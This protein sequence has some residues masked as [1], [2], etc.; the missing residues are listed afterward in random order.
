MFMYKLFNFP[1]VNV[2]TIP[3][4]SER[5]DYL[6]SQFYN[7]NVKNIKINTFK[8]FEPGDYIFDGE[9]VNLLVDSHRGIVSS[10]LIS[11]KNWY[12][13]TNEQYSIF[14]EDDL[15]L[16]TVNFWPF[17]WSTF[18]CALPENWG[19]IQLVL[20]KENKMTDYDFCFRQRNWDDWSACCYMIKR[21][22]AKKI[23]D[24]YYKKNIFTLSY[25]GMDEY[26]RKNSNDLS[27]LV[28][29]TEN[30]I[31]SLVEPIYTIPLFTENINFKSSTNL[32]IEP[33]KQIHQA[34]GHVESNLD[35][36]NWWKL[37]GINLNDVKNHP[38]VF[39]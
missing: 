1:S 29:C 2:I 6:K 16:D 39:G 14:C 13:S 33:E 26:K 3:E 15:S 34:L 32:F 11:I 27:W 20:V 18:F 37:G 17:D 31:Y 24:F 9:Y 36:L 23:L 4:C 25:R 7:Y 10:H 5:I 8:K 12:N 19:C 22:F 28:P 38:E 35:V 21:S 30:I